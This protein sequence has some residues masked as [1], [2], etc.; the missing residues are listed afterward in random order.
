MITFDR[1]HL[2]PNV[3]YFI[4]GNGSFIYDCKLGKIIAENVINGHNVNKLLKQINHQLIKSMTLYGR[5]LIY[6]NALETN[7]NHYVLDP[8]KNQISSLLNYQNQKLDLIVIETNDQAINEKL[9][10]EIN[11]F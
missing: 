4:G 6:T 1:L 11:Q 10:N 5:D 9:A 2:N 8:F 3:D 7:D